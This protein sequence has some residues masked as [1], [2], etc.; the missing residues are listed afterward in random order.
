MPVYNVIADDTILTAILISAN[1]ADNGENII[2][3]GSRPDE[4]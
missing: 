3:F 1:R 2:K 4:S